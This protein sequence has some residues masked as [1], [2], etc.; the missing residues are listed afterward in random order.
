M[1]VPYRIRQAVPADATVLC[2][3]ERRCF[4]DPWSED[5][6][7]EVLRSVW[8]VAVVAES[9]LLA[10]GLRRLRAHAVEEVYLEVRVSN[11][12]AQELYL[13]AGF[14]EIGQRTGYYRNPREDALVLRLDVTADRR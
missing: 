6:F 14:R 2:D 7:R 11:R 10:E 4:T 13:T 1:D 9:A 3:I 8:T 12:E 5:S